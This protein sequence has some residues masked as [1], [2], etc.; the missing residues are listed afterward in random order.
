TDADSVRTVLRIPEYDRV[1]RRAVSVAV[2]YLAQGPA[3]HRSRVDGALDVR[4]VD[5]RYAQFAAKSTGENDGIRASCD[6]D[7]VL[8]ELGFG[9]ESLLRNSEHHSDSTAVVHFERASKNECGEGQHVADF[10]SRLIRGVG[11]A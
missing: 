3:L 7:D 2:R 5:H 8:P 9:I 11:R 6:D 1:Q 10:A 4:V